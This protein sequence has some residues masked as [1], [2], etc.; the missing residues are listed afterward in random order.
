MHELGSAGTPEHTLHPEVTEPLLD[1]GLQ[2]LL[3]GVG[4]TAE[5]QVQAARS[6]GD[7]RSRGVAEGEAMGTPTGA[8]PPPG[9][10]NRPSLRSTSPIPPSRVQAQGPPAVK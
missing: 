1:L 4:A 2:M 10:E 5:C 3:L 8:G 7:Y 9:R 6:V